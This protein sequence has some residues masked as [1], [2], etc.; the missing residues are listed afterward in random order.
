MQN[1]K[2][3]MPWSI[4]C[5]V[6][7]L[8]VSLVAG[9]K[10]SQK[11]CC[12]KPASAAAC[13][14]AAPV[15]APVPTATPAPAAAVAPVA[16]PVAAPAAAPQIVRI[17]AGLLTSYTDAAGNVWLADQGFADGDITERAEDLQITNTPSPAL[18][19]SERYG[20]TSFSYP[21]PNGKYTVK[22]HFA[23][24]FEG[25]TGPGERVFSFTVEGHEFKDFDV[26]AKAGG[27]LRA[28]VE[29]V[30]ADITDGKLDISFS[31]KVENP[32]INGI[33]IIPAP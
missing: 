14:A 21:V 16:A 26:Y 20:M 18:Y 30:E 27:P 29:T 13:E 17:K 10:C 31:S 15:A 8:A 24:T 4:V 5:V 25:V 28:Y 11:A 1:L 33:E 3:F 2:R 23:E 6:A 7:V 22:L 32:Q 9:C 19:R 12:T